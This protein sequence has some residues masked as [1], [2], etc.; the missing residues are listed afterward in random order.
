M[1]EDNK[2]PTQSG[3]AVDK[4]AN[5]L[6]PGIAER[7]KG[8]AARL[9]AYTT[10]KDVEVVAKWAEDT[11]MPGNV[12][13]AM[14]NYVFEWRGGTRRVAGYFKSVT[15]QIKEETKTG[16]H[17]PGMAR[18]VARARRADQKREDSSHL[19]AILEDKVSSVGGR[20]QAHDVDSR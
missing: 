15:P 6:L 14:T 12:R 2:T 16:G 19:G 13:R 17:R 8:G 7:S 9:S 20:L 3:T 18:L 4:V 1:S 5:Q 11:E 10:M